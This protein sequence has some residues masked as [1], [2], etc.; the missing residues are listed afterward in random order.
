MTT[1]SSKFCRS[2]DSSTKVLTSPTHAAS[3]I[4]RRLGT[5]WQDIGNASILVK[6]QF[7]E[8]PDMLIVDF[9]LLNFLRICIC[10]SVSMNWRFYVCPVALRMVIPVLDTQLESFYDR[11]TRFFPHF[12]R[13][14]RK[15]CVVRSDH[16]TKIH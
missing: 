4:W 3:I 7:Y 2:E 8:F 15:L 9:K 16:P 12:E 10:T 11:L 1:S 6:V 14:T 5:G 13:V